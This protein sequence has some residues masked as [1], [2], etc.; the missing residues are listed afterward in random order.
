MIHGNGPDRD[1]VRSIINLLS[2][3]D[4]E[5]RIKDLGLFEAYA[6]NTQLGTEYINTL[7][8]PY[9]LVLQK[10]KLGSNVTLENLVNID[11]LDTNR[12]SVEEIL[13]KL[14]ILFLI[15]ENNGVFKALT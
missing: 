4:S 13:K 15:E 9:Y 5:E 3:Q 6:S 1:K 12:I 7:S 8:Y 2:I 10:I 11:G 14:R